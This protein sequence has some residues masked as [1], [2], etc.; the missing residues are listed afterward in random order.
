MI[1]HFGNL[2]DQAKMAAEI[3]R[4]ENGYFVQTLSLLC[5]GAAF[6][7]PILGSLAIMGS[8]RASSPIRS[9]WCPAEPDRFKQVTRDGCEMSRLGKVLGVRR[10]FAD[11][12]VSGTLSR[13]MWE[14]A[15]NVFSGVFRKVAV[16][17]LCSYF[18][19]L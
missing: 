5:I 11:F 13:L 6:S 7:L 9:R 1:G 14:G 18:Q 4:V 15:M 17:S 8:N 10:F 2:A 12:D 16:P 3:T 19:F